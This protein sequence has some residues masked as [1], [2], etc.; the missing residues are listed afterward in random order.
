MQSARAALNDMAKIRDWGDAVTVV[1][2][3]GPPFRATA[4]LAHHTCPG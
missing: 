3:D 2:T 1:T 4:T